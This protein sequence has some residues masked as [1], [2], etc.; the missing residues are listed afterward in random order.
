M[1]GVINEEVVVRVQV[2]LHQDGRAHVA[3]GEV[4]QA[5]TA[6][7]GAGVLLK[8]VVN[9]VLAVAA[10]RGGGGEAVLRQRFGSRSVN[11]RVALQAQVTAAAEI[12]AAAAVDDGHR[13]GGA[14]HFKRHGVIVIVINLDT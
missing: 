4:K 11:A 2:R 1:G 10:A 13:S 5:F 7:E 8:F 12:V 9:R 6:K 14:L 3:A